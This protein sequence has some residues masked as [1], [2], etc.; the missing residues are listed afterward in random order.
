MKFIIVIVLK[1]LARNTTGPGVKGQIR[2]PHR[3]HDQRV[4]EREASLRHHEGRQE[5]GRQGLRNRHG[6]RN[7]SP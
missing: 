5:P 4:H 2:V 6:Q 7:W 3:V 1:Y